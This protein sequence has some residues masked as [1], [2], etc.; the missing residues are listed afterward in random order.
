MYDVHHATGG[1]DPIDF[2]TQFGDSGCRPE[3]VQPKLEE[4][5][6]ALLRNPDG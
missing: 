5:R 3:I 6:R 1:F 4:L 2:P